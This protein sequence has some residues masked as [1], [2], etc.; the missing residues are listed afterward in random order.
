MGILLVTALIALAPSVFAR[1]GSTG[2]NVMVFTFARAVAGVQPPSA[3][4][5]VSVNTH[6]GAVDVSLQGF[7]PGAQLQLIFAG[8]S[9]I[10]VGPVSVDMLGKGGAGFTLPQGLYSGSFQLLGS[11]IV[12]M[13]TGQATFTVGSGGTSTTAMHTRS[14]PP[15]LVNGWAKAN[16]TVMSTTF[17]QT[18]LLNGVVQIALSSFSVSSSTNGQ[19]MANVASNE[20]I[21]QVEFDHDGGVELVIHSSAMP[22]AVYADDRL[23]IQASSTAGLNVNSNAWVYDRGSATLTVFADPGTVTMFYG[24]A[25]IPEFPISLASLTMILG[26]IA[27]AATVT[28]VRRKKTLNPS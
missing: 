3:T 26:I 12:Q 8:G 15:G 2:A 14:E 16:V 28:A 24:S 18:V 27:A 17:A 7:T 1:F 11:S 25:P 9:N 21:A 22:A 19:V 4:G 5:T 10:V 20:N 13:I 6:T 23:L